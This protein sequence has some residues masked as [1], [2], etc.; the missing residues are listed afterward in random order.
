[1]LILFS[2]SQLLHVSSMKCQLVFRSHV[3]SAV[4]HT[5]ESSSGY[6][7]V[8]PFESTHVCV[9]VI[10]CVCALGSVGECVC[11]CVFTSVYVY[12]Y[13]HVFSKKLKRNQNFKQTKNTRCALFFISYHEHTVPVDFFILRCGRKFEVK[14]EVFF[15]R[16]SKGIYDSTLQFPIGARP[17]KSADTCT[18]TITHCTLTLFDH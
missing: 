16:Y 18:L 2:S 9:H 14:H 3:S 8:W 11:V 17:H 15:L 5:P 13:V 7:G 1:M 6:N 4:V 10:V 12:M